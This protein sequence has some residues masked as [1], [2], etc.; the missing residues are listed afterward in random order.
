[1]MQKYCSACAHC[2]DASSRHR[3]RKVS[4]N[5][6]RGA[7]T[8]QGTRAHSSVPS[9]S[10]RTLSRT[11]I[12]LIMV[13]S[14][15]QY[16]Q[17]SSHWIVCHIVARTHSWCKWRAYCR[18]QSRKWHLHQ[19]LQAWWCHSARKAPPT[20]SQRSAPETPEWQCKSPGWPVMTGGLAQQPWTCPASFCLPR[21]PW[22][23]PALK[24]PWSW[25][26]PLPAM[27]NL[28]LNLPFLQPLWLCPHWLC[29]SSCPHH[30][31]CHQ[32]LPLLLTGILCSLRRLL[33]SLN[34]HR[35]RGPRWMSLFRPVHKLS[36]RR[37]YTSPTRY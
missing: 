1:M 7:T 37:N 4:I 28:S 35:W 20:L 11:G 24:T 15:H 5:I 9:L 32:S 25:C 13:Q 33:G 36:T 2:L 34:C 26:S 29:L 12:G 3:N 31:P 23:P 17:F 14:V 10:W 27:N 22:P 16:H 30:Q 18:C 21:W 6:G 8:P 19:Q